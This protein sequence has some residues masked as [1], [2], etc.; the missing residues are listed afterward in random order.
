MSSDPD[1]GDVPDQAREVAEQY[2]HTLQYAS[3]F[4][5]GEADSQKAARRLSARL[6]ELGIP[7]AIAGG[8]AVGAHGHKRVTVDVDVILTAEGLAEF[9]RTSLGLGWVERFKGSKGMRDTQHNVPIDVSVAGEYPGDGKPKSVCFPDPSDLNLTDAAT[10]VVPLAT[11]LE[12]KIASGIS[13]PHR[14]RDLADVLDLIRCNDLSREYGR[15]L[16]PYVREKFDEL[17]GLA[18]HSD[19]S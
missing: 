14:L 15:Q 16:D 7:H 12:L 1:P 11:L 17:W 10:P 6:R 4:F 5:M 13:A 9:K 2:E 19:E 18:Q 8:L 3:A